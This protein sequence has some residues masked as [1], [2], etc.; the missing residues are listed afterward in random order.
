MPS[1]YRFVLKFGAGDTL[2]ETLSSIKSCAGSARQL[3]PD[4]YDALSQDMKPSTADPF[5]AFR[6]AML[7]LAYT[8]P[9]KI[10]SPSDVKRSF[11]KEYKT[12]VEAANALMLEVKK[13][14]KSADPSDDDGLSILLGSFESELIMLALGKQHKEMIL[15]ADSFEG[16]A[17]VLCERVKEKCGKVISTKWDGKKPA[18]KAASSSGPKAGGSTVSLQLNYWR[19]L[20]E[21]VLGSFKRKLSKQFLS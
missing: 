2:D 5:L 7:R 18:P 6:H 17:Y 10:L 11:G 12:K 8:G 21:F 16:A 13:L 20:L 14:I 15:N 3:G 19:Y 1:M 4:L 9:E